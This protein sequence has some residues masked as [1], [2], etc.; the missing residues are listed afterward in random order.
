MSETNVK[1]LA[2]DLDGTLTNSEKKISEGNRRALFAAME[3]GVQTALVSG[4]PCLGIRPL[5]EELELY[6]RGGFIL[7][8]NGGE[9]IDCASRSIIF[10]ETIPM[11]I[12]PKICETAREL[13][14]HLVSYDDTHIYSEH[15]EGEYVQKESFCCNADIIRADRLE[16]ILSAEPVK[17]IA[18][19]DPA[20]LKRALPVMQERFGEDL[21]IFFS[22]PYFMEITPK[23]IDKAYG[24][25]RLAAYLG[26]SRMNIMA[27]G[28][29]YNDIPMMNYAGVS[30]AMGNAC[31]EVKQ[32]ARFVTATNDEDGVAR[33]VERFILKED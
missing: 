8:Y 27:C 32:A 15:P 20:L 9:I 30:V 12:V 2:L 7:A 21:N 1:V 14:M 16:E 33:A 29:G 6:E 24:L 28:D 4:R 18:A 3:R 19:N 11:R 13:G 31:E 5:A 26:I 25:S 22:E 17:F 23:V 10:R